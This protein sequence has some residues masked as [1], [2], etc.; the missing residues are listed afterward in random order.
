MGKLFLQVE[1]MNL[2]GVK[3]KKML[4]LGNTSYK[5]IDFFQAW[6]EKGGGRSL[7]EFFNPFFHHVVPYI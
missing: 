6:P 3:N 1:K 2:A 4:V 5:K 7:P